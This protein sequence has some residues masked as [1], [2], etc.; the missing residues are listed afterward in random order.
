MAIKRNYT[1]NEQSTENHEPE[2]HL[3]AGKAKSVAAATPVQSINEKPVK[4]KKEKKEKVPRA[5]GATGR[6][7]QLHM[8]RK[9]TD[10][11]ILAKVKAE[12]PDR[13]DKQI[14]VYLSVQR[15]EINS[16]RKAGF[17]LTEGEKPLERLVKDAAGK[18]VPYSSIPKKQAVKKEKKL[19][20][21]LTTGIVDEGG[22]VQKT[23]EP[24][25]VPV[26]KRVVAA[27]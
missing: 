27:K 14:K 7:C 5:L 15:A 12:Y 23:P 24:A 25:P 26:R 6:V 10:E 3:T 13:T 16:G 20:K 22:L 9:F 8:E 1:E 11:E 19:L 18:T 4:A 2:T 21:E 17:K